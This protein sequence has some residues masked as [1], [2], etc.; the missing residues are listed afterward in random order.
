[1]NKTCG[2]QVEKQEWTHK[3]HSLVDSYTWTYLCCRSALCIGCNLEHL[4]GWWM[5]G[6]DG[7]KESG[8]S[9][10]SAGLN[11]DNVLGIS[12]YSAQE[13]IWMQDYQKTYWARR[14]VFSWDELAEWSTVQLLLFKTD[15]VHIYQPLR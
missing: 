8:N 10:L 2:T 4:L 6:M 9:V 1:M 7:K 3:R 5:I 15:R 13:I 14:W 12:L 11:V